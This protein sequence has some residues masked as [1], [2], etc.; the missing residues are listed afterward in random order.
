MAFELSVDRGGTVV[1]V[2]NYLDLLR[3]C[4]SRLLQQKETG[5]FFG[6]T[7]STPMTR[8]N[9]GVSRGQIDRT[10]SARNEGSSYLQRIGGSGRPALVTLLSP[11]G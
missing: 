11:C 8:N 9:L 2:T 10:Q 1:W 6:E 7:H 4:V 5:V 3:R